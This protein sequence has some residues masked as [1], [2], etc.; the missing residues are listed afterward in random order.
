MPGIGIRPGDTLS[1]ARLAAA[2]ATVAVA[3]LLSSCSAS[4]SSGGCLE[5]R[6]AV[7]PE[8]EPVVA[9]QAAGFDRKVDGRC[10]SV[11]VRSLAP[12]HGAAVLTGQEL[13]Q[14]PS[15]P[16][17]WVPDSSLWIPVA[18][19]TTLGA[20][21][22]AA[23]GPSLASSPLV[24]ALSA[25][26]AAKM[27]AD[28]PRPSWKELLVQKVGDEGG[29]APSGKPAFELA[30]PATTTA[31]LGTLLAMHRNA[32]HGASG[33]AP[34]AVSLYGFEFRTTPDVSTLVSHIADASKPVTGIVP[35]QAV[36]AQNSADP[37]AA[38]VALPPAEGSIYLDYPYV[39]TTKDHQR[40]DA[41]AAF[42]R[43][44]RSPATRDAVDAAGFRAPDHE[45]G[46]GLWRAVPGGVE[47][48][49]LTPP[50]TA[51][52]AQIRR[53]WSR[54]ALGSQLLVLLDVSPS[55]GDSV[56]G[57]DLTRLGAI[58]KVAA[59]GLRL[60]GPTTENGLWMFAT[61]LDGDRDYKE[62]VPL[63]RLDSTHDGKTQR[64]RLEEAYAGAQPKP[65]TRTG[66]YDSILASYEYMQKKYAPNRNNLVV[67]FTD[68]KDHD[69]GAGISLDTLLDRIRQE[70]D[71]MR[72]VAIIPIA[73]GK[74]IDPTALNKI[75]DLTG[76]EAFVTLNPDQIQQVFL[77]MLIRLTC[78]PECPVP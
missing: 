23:S 76:S 16:D 34:F 44:L 71:S 46:D 18:R 38:L 33:L 78:D 20:T 54:I 29:T 47:P 41:V 5:I 30:D 50:S 31:G 48:D 13:D 8:L 36:W 73:F 22:V 28:R 2:V 24:F 10:V 51:V 9:R 67:V 45:A 14:D 53:M 4:S 63:A 57:T 52:T 35:E 40:A 49:T 77:K 70:S 7:T 56:P 61:K 74:D 59:Q 60:F 55:M 58:T 39:T 26:V 37:D 75:A 27:P 1:R 69:P 6:V 68:G 66:L 25:K 12:S 43:T 11:R 19:A 72:P 15:R 21:N 64:E 32:P 17:A 3:G 42:G 62:A 65:H